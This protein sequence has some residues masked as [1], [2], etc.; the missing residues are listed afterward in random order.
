[1]LCA[2]GSWSG[3]ILASAGLNVPVRP[4]R[5]QIV[6][7]SVRPQFL[8]QLLHT[9]KCYLTPWPDGRTILGATMEK[10][11]YDKTVTAGGVNALLAAATDLAPDL[12]AAAITN[13]WAGL[14]PD[15]SDNL[16]VLGRT[17]LKNLVLATGHF[18]NGILLTPVTAQLILELLTG[19]PLSHALEPFS[20]ERFQTDA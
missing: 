16:P 4:V 10:V 1:M 15:T 14:R 2:G 17:P 8:R 3:A 11:G 5:G 19:K 20:V 13:T 9:G 6:E 7:L 18:R 12:G